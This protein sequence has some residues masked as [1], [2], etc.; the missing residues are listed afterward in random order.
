MQTE[1]QTK[2]STGQ[3]ITPFLWFDNNAEEAVNLYTS[4][5]DNSK[6]DSVVRYSGEGAK[7]AHMPE[8]RVMT[9][10]FTLDGQKFAAINGGPMFKFTEAVS[11]VINCEGQ[12]EVDKFWN[13]LIADGGKESQCG[14]LKDKFGLSW[15][16]VPGA[17]LRM[18][19]DKDTAK[20]QRVMQAMLQMKKIIVADLEKATNEGS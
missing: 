3:K 20:S 19:Q 17:L 6:I 16:V 9:M 13:K 2:I 1:N 4:I 15:Q 18:L 5:F 12:E 14:W 10:G 11:F 7:A 8:G